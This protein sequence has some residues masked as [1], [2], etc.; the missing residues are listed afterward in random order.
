MQ[1]CSTIANMQSEPVGADWYIPRT[2]E[3]VLGRA[4]QEFPAVVVVGPRQSGKTTM[5]RHAVGS[6]MQIVSL[7]PPDVRLAAATDPRGFLDLHPPPVVFDEI[8][9]VPGLLPYIKEQVDAHR[10][11]AGQF[12]LT[13]SQNLLLMA[14]VT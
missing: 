7:D 12:L 14:Q 4:V 10:E 1:I 2:L 6:R 11:R 5:L 3:A 13:G 9:H 8:Q